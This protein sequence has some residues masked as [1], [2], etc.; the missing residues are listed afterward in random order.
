MKQTC[1]FVLLLCWIY[2]PGQ[3]ISFDRVMFAV[4]QNRA[5]LYYYNL[6]VKYFEKENFKNA[7][8]AFTYSIETKPNINAYYKLAITKIKEGD[9]CNYCHNLK[10]ASLLGDE[11]SKKL[12]SL[13]CSFDDD[14]LQ[15]FYKTHE[16]LFTSEVNIHPRQDAWF[17]LAVAKAML[18][19]QCGF[20]NCLQKMD[21]GYLIAPFK[22]FFKYCT[23]F[24]DITILDTLQKNDKIINHILVNACDTNKYLLNI[25]FRINQKN[26]TVFGYITAKVTKGIIADIEEIDSNDYE[27]IIYKIDTTKINSDTIKKFTINKILKIQGESP[28]YYL[29]EV[30]PYFPGGKE[31]MY[32]FIQNHIRYPEIAKKHKISGIV[33]VQFIIEK[34]GTVTNLKILKD[35]GGGCGDEALRVVRLM[36]IW[37]PA[38][39]KGRHVRIKFIMPVKF[40]FE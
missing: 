27:R 12:Y 11:T 23:Y 3:I 9:T 38:T 18:G 19:N 10:K 6:G 16:K 21:R 15:N 25:F 37:I 5:S 1:F 26:D 39:Q 33:I 20:C 17:N 34:N 36:P 35:I 31:G 13:D 8:S 28:V 24:K 30:M 2:S 14:R 22:L 40:P 7:D 29:A 32:A 4:T